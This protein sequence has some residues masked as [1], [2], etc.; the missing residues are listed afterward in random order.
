MTTA[1]NIL[2]DMVE[3]LND[4][5]KFYREAAQKVARPDLKNLFERM[6]VT[7]AAIAA[8]LKGK[9]IIKGEQPDTNGSISGSLRKAYAEVIAKFSSNPDATYIEQLEAFEDRILHTFKE[10]A[11]ECKDPAVQAIV[12]KH[13][14]EVVRD[15][16]DMR[17]LKRSVVQ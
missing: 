10:A 8:D 16:N 4:G 5:K 1:T 12:Q 17:N 7:K 2:N 13:M 11:E 14:A 9:I 15:H 3:V 6:A